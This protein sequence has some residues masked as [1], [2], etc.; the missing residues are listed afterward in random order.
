MEEDSLSRPFVTVSLVPSTFAKQLNPTRELVRT[1]GGDAETSLLWSTR[2][3]TAA[4][5]ADDLTKALVHCPSLLAAMNARRYVF[6]TSD[7]STSVKT[8]LADALRD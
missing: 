8:N 3:D 6:V 5:P 2:S 4:M 7:S 1:S